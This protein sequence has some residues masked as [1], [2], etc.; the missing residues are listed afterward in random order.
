MG[1]LDFLANE[2]EIRDMIET[3]AIKAAQ[4]YAAEG[5]KRKRKEEEGEKEG[6]DDIEIVKADT[7]DEASDDETPAKP[8]P[9]KGANATK[10]RGGEVSGLVKVRV[11]QFQD[12][13]RC[14]G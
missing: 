1:N 8:A 5:K 14:K 7:D 11:G 2:E 3:N 12:T 13:G 4:G 10:S 9:A 6:D